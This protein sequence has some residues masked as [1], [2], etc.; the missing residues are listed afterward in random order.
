MG[1][2]LAAIRATTG[3]APTHWARR[4]ASDSYSIAGGMYG[5]GSTWWASPSAS[6]LPSGWTVRVHERPFDS[7]RH[8]QGRHPQRHA[9]LALVFASL[10]QI[11][12]FNWAL[13]GFPGAYADQWP[14]WFGQ[15]LRCARRRSFRHRVHRDRPRGGSCST[16]AAQRRYPDHRPVS[17]YVAAPSCLEASLRHPWGSACPGRRGLVLHAG[18]GAS[19]PSTPTPPH[20]VIPGR[21]PSPI[22]D[23]G[24]HLLATG[25]GPPDGS[26]PATG[27]APAPGWG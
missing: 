22:A 17:V 26:T 10:I 5:C 3:S 13:L 6:Q 21:S 19:S 14:G 24:V 11:L 16:G 1:E 4:F 8:A 23:A 18:R 2:R 12:N 25:W 27:T 7:H 9:V 20:V 15:T